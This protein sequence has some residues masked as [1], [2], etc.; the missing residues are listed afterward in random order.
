[1][2]S[3]IVCGKAFIKARGRE[4]GDRKGNTSA[5]KS[6]VSRQ[7]ITTA[8]WSEVVYQWLSLEVSNF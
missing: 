4:P 7:L 8:L 3:L 6:A 2:I 1:M 5:M